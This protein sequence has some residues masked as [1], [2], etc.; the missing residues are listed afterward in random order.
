MTIE[1][2][3]A[4][5]E[6][7]VYGTIPTMV[8]NPPSPKYISVS[9]IHIEDEYGISRGM[10]GM[11]DKGQVGLNLSDENGN[12]RVVLNT[13]GGQSGLLVTDNN[14]EVR[15]QLVMSE[16]GPTLI[17]NNED[18]KPSIMIID[19]KAGPVLRRFGKN[20]EDIPIF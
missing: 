19:S 13:D 16:H 1:E 9:A 5:L 4:K 20:G 14:N 12:P 2:R 6:Q 18:G 3:L 11:T 8:A 17:L 15:I 10:I 7:V